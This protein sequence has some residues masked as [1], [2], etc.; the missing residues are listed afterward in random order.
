MTYPSVFETYLDLSLHEDHRRR[1]WRVLWIRQHVLPKPIQ[2]DDAKSNLNHMPSH[3]LSPLP[4]MWERSYGIHG[5]ISNEVIRSPI[6]ESVD[7]FITWPWYRSAQ[8][9]ASVHETSWYISD[10]KAEA[11]RDDALQKSMQVTGAARIRGESLATVPFL[12]MMRLN[13]FISK[14]FRSVPRAKAVIWRP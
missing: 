14:Y 8:V 7:V 5:F 1:D 12:G 4:T 13:C 2:Q 6:Q 3:C 9:L 10:L 11:R